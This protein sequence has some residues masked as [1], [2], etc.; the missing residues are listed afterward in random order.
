MVATKT[1]IEHNIYS[2]L[3]SFI[4]HMQT[5]IW[6]AYCSRVHSSIEYTANTVIDY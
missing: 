1:S 3:D 5:A 2:F 4:G 6:N